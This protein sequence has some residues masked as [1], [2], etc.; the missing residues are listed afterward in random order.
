MENTTP[1]YLSKGNKS[2]DQLI[3]QISCNNI[4]EDLRQMAIVMYQ[5]SMLSLQRSLWMTYLQS[6]TGKLKSNHQT[7]EVGPQIW[8]AEVVQSKMNTKEPTNDNTWLTYVTKY[9]C[10]LDTKIKQ[11]QI[12]LNVK[13]IPMSNYIQTIETYVQQGL[14]SVRLEIEHKIALV[15]YDYNDRTLELAFLQHHPTEYQVSF[16]SSNILSITVFSFDLETNRQTSL[17]SQI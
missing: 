10:E 13:K 4:I 6:G 15:Q 11:Y 12:E 14:E 8:P 5:L 1:N 7:T 2:F 17:S 9:L 16:F 3:C